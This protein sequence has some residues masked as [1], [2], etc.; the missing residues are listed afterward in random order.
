MS[1]WFPVLFQVEK[2]TIWS[3]ITEVEA[4]LPGSLESKLWMLSAIKTFLPVYKK[5]KWFILW[6]VFFVLSRRHTRS[7]AALCAKW[8]D[9]VQPIPGTVCFP[10]SASPSLWIWVLF[11]MAL[12]SKHVWKLLLFSSWGVCGWVRGEAAR[13]LRPQPYQHQMQVDFRLSIEGK[14]REGGK[15]MRAIKPAG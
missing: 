14:E 10:C 15:L 3:K 5:C 2:E 12:S 13:L 4:S 6:P 1:Q 9:A 11:L 7:H 8:G